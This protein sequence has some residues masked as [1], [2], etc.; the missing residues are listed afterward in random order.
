[1]PPKNDVQPTDA[2]NGNV[3]SVAVYLEGQP[4]S[5]E[6]EPKRAQ[7]RPSKFTPEVKSQLLNLIED[8]TPI[9]TACAIVGIG[10]S[11]FA[12]WKAQAATEGEE[13]EFAR[14]FCE[15]SRARGIAE[16]N[17]IDQAR[18]G[19]GREYSRGPAVNSQWLLERQFGAQYA[20]RVNMKLEEMGD[21]YLDIITRVCSAKDCGCY[22]EILAAVSSSETGDGAA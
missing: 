5:T 20:P 17:L 14:F 21:I 4:M 15:V 16:K 6:P 7:G 10:Q 11:T 3:G 8:C 2:V 13:G 19:D 18:Q 22:S 1:M 9:K 12:T